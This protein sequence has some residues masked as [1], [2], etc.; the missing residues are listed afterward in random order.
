MCNA[1]DLGLDLQADLLGAQRT[2]SWGQ[3]CKQTCWE[4]KCAKHKTAF[5]FKMAQQAG[6]CQA[7]TH[8]QDSNCD[9]RTPSRATPQAQAKTHIASPSGAVALPLGT[10]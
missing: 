6:R 1:R 3:I 5:H 7:F 4:P 9:P 2:R 8:G 10:P